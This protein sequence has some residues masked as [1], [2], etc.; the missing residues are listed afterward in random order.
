MRN[1]LLLPFTARQ[2]VAYI[3]D[4]HTNNEINGKST[5]ACK[6]EIKLFYPGVFCSGIMPYIMFPPN[7]L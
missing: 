1:L 5:W 3:G 6:T 2:D 4:T 7:E